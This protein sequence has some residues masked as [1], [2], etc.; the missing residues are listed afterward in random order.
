LEI[1]IKNNSFEAASQTRY[2]ISTDATPSPLFTFGNT[3][4]FLWKI[5]FDKSA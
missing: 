1:D 2:K 4:L 5:N 3:A